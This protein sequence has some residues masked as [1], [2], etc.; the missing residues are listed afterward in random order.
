MTAIGDRITLAPLANGLRRY[1]EA[2]RQF[3]M[4]GSALPDLLTYSAAGLRR[5]LA[6]EV[7]WLRSRVS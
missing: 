4:T 2:T 7:H 5:S 6:V 3:G 1:A